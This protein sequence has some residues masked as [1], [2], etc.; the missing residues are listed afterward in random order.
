M[1][2]IDAHECFAEVHIS[3]AML[4]DSA[5]DLESEMGTEFAE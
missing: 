1:M 5:F 4:E 3:Q 2:T